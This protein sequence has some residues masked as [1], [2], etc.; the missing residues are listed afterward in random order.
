M[1]KSVNPKGQACWTLERL[2]E[3]LCDWAYEVYETRVHPALGMTPREA[4]ASGMARMG[5]RTHR[6]MRDEDF[7]MS[8]LPTTRKGTAKV[9]SSHGVKINSATLVGRLP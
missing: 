2:Y 8:T 4:F 9:D 5:V 7:R 3:H 6:R 1:T